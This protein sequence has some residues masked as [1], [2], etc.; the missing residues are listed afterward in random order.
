M[1][2]PSNTVWGSINYGGSGQ[3]RIG[4]AVSYTDLNATTVRCTMDVWLWTRYRAT[5]NTNAFDVCLDTDNAE[6]FTAL[7][8]Q[9]IKTTSN[10]EW[11]TDNQVWIGYWYIDKVKTTSPQYFN[12]GVAY[13]NIEYG[14]SSGYCYAGYSIPA[15]T[16]YTVSYNANGGSNAPSSQTKWYGKNLTLSSSVP[17]RAGHTFK[18]WG[19]SSTDTTVDYA[20]GGVYTGNSSITLYAIWQ[21]HTYEVWFD[22]NGGTD[23]PAGLTKTYNVALPIPTKIPTRTDYNFLGW[24]ANKTAT[25]PTFVVGDNYTANS[26]VTL[27]AVWEIA[28]IRPRISNFIVSR[29]DENGVLSDDAEHIKVSFDY[30]ADYDTILHRVYV[31]E[32]TQ[33]D[34][35]Y[36]GSNQRSTSGTSGHVEYIVTQTDGKTPLVLSPEYSYDV[37]INVSDGYGYSSEVRRIN[38]TF[39]PIDITEN[40]E[41]MSFGEP[42]KDTSIENGVL[43]FAYDYVDLAPKKELLYHG[44]NFF[45]QNLLWSGLSLMNATHSI[46]LSK[47]IS[48]TKNGLLLV[49][50]RNGDY[51]FAPYFVP[52]EIVAMHER[53]TYAFPLLTSLF[54]YIGQK[55]LNISDTKIEGHADNDKTGKNATSGITYHNEAFFLKYVY[56]V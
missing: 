34:D 54:D 21:P 26:G 50:S 41:N 15:L 23:A 7:K 18:G 40:G 17:S 4:I 22:A 8:N 53:T 47:P 27:Y 25:E 52:K 51:N 10:S 32:Y 11:S 46:T 42:A 33:S 45:A 29:V 2:A 43:R 24:S 1:A 9:S 16:S 13:Y 3:G 39:Y 35:L 56:E 20:K 48:E 19:T 37:K 6:W 28:Y 14:G 38:S 30:T 36:V 55:T 31:K 12:F 49:F 44:E 5:D